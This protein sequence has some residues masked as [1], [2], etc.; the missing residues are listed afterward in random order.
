MPGECKALTGIYTL[1]LAMLGSANLT[2]ELN[3]SAL[4]MFA[5]PAVAAKSQPIAHSSVLCC[6][7]YFCYI[8]LQVQQCWNM[9]QGLI[10]SLEE[11]IRALWMLARS[12]LGQQARLSSWSN[13]DLYSVSW[14]HR[15]CL[16]TSSRCHCLRR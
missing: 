15:L 8:H 1:E 14:R 12:T 6:N 3:L 10:A 5:T 9:Q 11:G 4:T 2:C 16:G 7:C 13:K